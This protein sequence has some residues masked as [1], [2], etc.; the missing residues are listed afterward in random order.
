L[1]T[2]SAIS[3]TDEHELLS[4]PGGEKFELRLLL[5]QTDA[6]NYGSHLAKVAA[7]NSPSPEQQKKFAALGTAL[8]SRLQEVIAKLHASPGK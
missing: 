5:T 3:K 1:A 6:L 8:N 4:T 2:R 7:E